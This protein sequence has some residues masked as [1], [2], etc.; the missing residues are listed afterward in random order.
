[1]VEFNGTPFQYN[2]AVTNVNI[3]NQLAG[4]LSQFSDDYIIDVVKDS[5]NNRFRIYSLPGP[6][7]V[8]AFES[9]FKQ[10]TDGFSSNTGEI[11]ETRKRVYMNIINIICDFYDLTFND[12]DE[13]D[14]YSAAYWL[15]DFL[16]SNFT[17]NL[18]NFYS[19]FLI[20]ESGPIVSALGLSQMR[21]DNDITLGYSKK[22][23]KNQ[24]IAMIHCDLEYVIAQISSFNIDLWTIL[25]CVYQSNQN[26]PTYINSLVSDYTGRFFKNHYQ[27]FV[28]QS[29]ESSDILTYIKLNLQQI[30]GQFESVDNYNK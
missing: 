17:E 1:M 10:L 14:Y 25:S 6:N 4:V 20:K 24:N 30:G 26:L 29:N 12:N 2:P 3:D 27:T 16:V 19:I 9:T 15:Y 5:L 13:T 23:F 7:V 11:L 21:K 18:K 8:A 22:L 28:M